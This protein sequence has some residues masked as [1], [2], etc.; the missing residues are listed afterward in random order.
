M[1]TIVV[2]SGILAL[3]CYALSAGFYAA[4]LRKPKP[5]WGWTATTLALA[6]A[7]LNLEALHA[8]SAALKSVPYRDLVGSM[9]LLGFFLAV[10]NLLLEMR[11]HDRSLGPFLMPV[12]F[13]FLFVALEIPPEARPPSPEL[14]GPVFALH[15]TANI[16]GYAAFAV[17]CALSALYLI[18]GR[19]LKSRKGLVLDGAASRLP[20]LSYLER[21]TR[22]TLG[23]G[24][25]A[26]TA[27]FLLGGYWATRVWGPGHP[28]WALDPKIFAAFAIVVFY[29]VVLVRAH[30]GAA[31]VTTA[32][33][34][35]V[36]FGLVLL[37]Y[38][39][40]N[41]LFSR[42]HVFT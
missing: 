13:L 2:V 38:T 22:T 41:L 19:S 26:S 42:L 6:G 37:S 18:A 11:H 33:L 20:S 39:A 14:K 9:A 8:R 23:L 30:R 29:W 15:V 24:V 3:V 28:G 4:F 31:P 35:M 21:A 5:A 10:L 40:I 36:G 34:S 7:L 16:F 32:R 12:V 17:A 1:P 27:G 25:F